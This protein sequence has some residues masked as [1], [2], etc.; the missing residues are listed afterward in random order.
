V[1]TVLVLLLATGAPHPQQ[2]A[3]DGPRF[4]CRVAYVHD[5]DTFR[6]TDGKRVRLAAIDAPEMP[7]VCQLGRACAPGD[8]LRAKAALE[9]LI[10]GR[11]VECQATGTTYNRIAAWC[12]VGATDLSCAMLRGGQAIRLPRFDPRGRLAHC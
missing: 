2:L 8:P 5:G 4:S 7:G 11:T 1:T 6:C 9:G 10:S 12:S 3:V